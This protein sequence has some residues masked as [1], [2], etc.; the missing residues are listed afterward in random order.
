M[1]PVRLLGSG[2]LQYQMFSFCQAFWVL[3][4]SVT[5]NTIFILTLKLGALDQNDSSKRKWKRE[6][7]SSVE[8]SSLTT[9]INCSALIRSM[10]CF[11]FAVSPS[12]V[13]WPILLIRPLHTFCTPQ[14]VSPAQWYLSKTWKYSRN[15][16]Y[17]I[18]KTSPMQVHVLSDQRSSYSC[19]I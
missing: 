10:Q 14:V 18:Y 5:I 7:Q 13:N 12:S 15:L 6:S 9:K 11:S 3:D 17:F 16:A 4:G 19:D 2:T 1:V 8:I